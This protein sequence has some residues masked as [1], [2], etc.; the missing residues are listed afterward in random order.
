MS[1]SKPPCSLIPLELPASTRRLLPSISLDD[2]IVPSY[3]VGEKLASLVHLFD[4]SSLRDLVDSSPV[5][6]YGDRGTGKTAL[7]ITL[8]VHWSRATSQRPLAICSGDSFSSDLLAAIEVDDLD[9][10]KNKYRKCKLLLIDDLDSIAS[11]PVTQQELVNTLDTLVDESA[12]VVI[13]CSKLPASM[14][15]L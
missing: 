15:N 12:P 1:D 14:K 13:N 8:A 11:K 7:S 10:F 6:F 9:S 2:W 5:V 4:S 3:A